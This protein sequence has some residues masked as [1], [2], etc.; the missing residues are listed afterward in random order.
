MRQR[1]LARIARNPIRTF[2]IETF[3]SSEKQFDSEQEHF[4]FDRLNKYPS[5]EIKKATNKIIKFYVS[6][7]FWKEIQEN[8]QK[9]KRENKRTYT[10]ETKREVAA[11]PLRKPFTFKSSRPSCILTRREIVWKIILNLNLNFQSAWWSF[12]LQF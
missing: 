9:R 8:C 2:K 5:F 7:Q 10:S 12:L 3:L 1:L 6:C 4:I 11:F